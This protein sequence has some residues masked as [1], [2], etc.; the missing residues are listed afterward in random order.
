VAIKPDSVYKGVESIGTSTKSW[1]EAASVTA[2]TSFGRDTTTLR[3][4]KSQSKL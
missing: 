1:Q 3:K 4:S 2:E